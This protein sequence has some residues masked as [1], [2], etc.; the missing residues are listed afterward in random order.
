MISFWGRTV[1]RNNR[2]HQNPVLHSVRFMKKIKKTKIS[3]TL[4][5]HLCYGYVSV[6]F[7]LLPPA[8]FLFSAAQSFPKSILVGQYLYTCRFSERDANSKLGKETR[9][10][11]LKTTSH[12]FRTA[13]VNRRVFRSNG[14]AHKKSL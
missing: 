8:L 12:S 4:P 3:P 13:E 1:Y 14:E 11:V 5:H 9:H 2:R 10:V 6:S 7:G